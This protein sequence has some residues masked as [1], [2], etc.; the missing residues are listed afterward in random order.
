MDLYYYCIQICVSVL[1]SIILFIVGKFLINKLKNNSIEFLNPHEYLPEEEVKTL[2]Q[3]F[4]LIIM[5]L[6]FY[7]LQTSFLTII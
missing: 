5:L 7:P 2:K 6:L 1:I 3:V 4:Y